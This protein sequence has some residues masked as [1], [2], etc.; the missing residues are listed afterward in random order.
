MFE[1]LTRVEPIE[2]TLI[3]VDVG[4]KCF[5]VIETISGNTTIYRNQQAVE[6]LK[7]WGI[8]EED[9][10]MYDIIHDDKNVIVYFAEA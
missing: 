4:Y 1:Q 5:M 10:D 7:S 9:I 2:G 8:E 3:F 6:M